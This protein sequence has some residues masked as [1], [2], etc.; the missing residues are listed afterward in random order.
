M[1]AG[2][3]VI[4]SDTRAPSLYPPATARLRPRSVRIPSRQPPRLLAREVDVQLE[5]RLDDLGMDGPRRPRTGRARLVLRG[6][7]PE[8]CLRHLRPSRVLDADEEDARY[9]GTASSL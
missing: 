4:Q 1:V 3:R 7:P 5:H 8:Q 9:F 6:R 2:W